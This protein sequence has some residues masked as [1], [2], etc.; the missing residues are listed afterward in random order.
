MVAEQAEKANGEGDAVADGSRAWYLLGLLTFCYALAYIDR[1]LVNLLVDDIRG[2]YALSDTQISYIIGLGF[3]LAYLIAAP[4]YGR[5]VDVTNRRNLLIVSVII[6]SLCTAAFGLVDSYWGLFAA[7]VG[8]GISEAGVLPIAWSL[9]ADSFSTRKLPAALSIFA[10]GQKLGSGLSLIAGGLVLTFAD[11]VQINFPVLA[12]FET[13]QF[14]FLIVGLPGVVF[15][16][17]L[18]TVKEPER[19]RLQA[20]GTV[21]KYTMREAWDYLWERRQ[22]YGRIYLGIGM[23]GILALGLPAWVPSFLM[24]AHGVASETVGLTMGA[25]FL[26]FGVA[27]VL[28]GPIAVRWFERRGYVDG[29]LRASVW[30]TGGI[31]LFTAAIPFMPGPA[32]A[33]AAIAGATY[34]F[35]FPTGIIPSAVQIGTPNRV[36]GFA[37]SLYTFSAQLVGFGVGPTAIAL[38]TDHLFEDPLKVGFSI[39]IVGC[40]AALLAGWLLFSAIRPFKRLLDEIH[41]AEAVP[42]RER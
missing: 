2:T 37:G 27:G 38:I 21:Q 31:I 3:A 8:V 11:A 20:A 30:A 13:W 16:L 1:Q 41:R 35:T 14:A 12:G 23:V 17:L 5:F 4:V 25:V 6:W 34:C 19:G 9:L 18:L 26:V 32:T 29:T 40:T 15:A 36:R 33:M 7:R 10:T 22:F 42:Q 39:A 24:R 28:S